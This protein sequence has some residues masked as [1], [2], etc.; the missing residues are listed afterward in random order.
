MEKRR[1]RAGRLK[2]GAGEGSWYWS[3][4]AAIAGAVTTSLV[5]YVIRILAI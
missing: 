2:R 5:V 3:C 4:F 1:K